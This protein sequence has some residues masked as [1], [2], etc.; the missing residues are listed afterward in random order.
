[1][2]TAVI[3]ALGIQASACFSA[4]LIA[5][6]PIAGSIPM[7]IIAAALFVQAALIV[8]ILLTLPELGRCQRPPSGQNS[9]TA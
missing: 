3:V 4:A 9:L 8:S 7:G 2:I 5:W 1:M 6:I